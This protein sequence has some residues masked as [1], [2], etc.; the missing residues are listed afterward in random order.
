V[1]VTIDTELCCGHGRCYQATPE[2]FTDDEGGYGQTINDGVVGRDQVEAARRAIV[3]C[4]E[5]AITI[6]KGG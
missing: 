5:K 2:L 4:P 1:R 3:A 6:S